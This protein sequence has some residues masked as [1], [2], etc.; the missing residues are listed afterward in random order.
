MTEEGEEES[1]FVLIEAVIPAASAGGTGTLAVDG[2]N[3]AGGTEANNAQILLSGHTSNPRLEDMVELFRQGI[4]TDDDNDL[5]QE[6]VPRHGETTTDSGNWRRERIICPRK[7]RNLQN[8][9]ASFIHYSHDSIL[10]MSLLQLFLIMFREDYLEE[11]LIPETN[12]VLNVPMDLQEFIK[13]VGCWLYMAC[14]VGI[15]SR[16]DWWSTMTPS[17][18][19]GAPFRLNLIISRNQ[20]DSILSALRFTNGEVPYEDGFFQ[21]RQLEEAWNHNMAQH[22]LP[23]WI[24]VIDEYMM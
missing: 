24:N 1:L 21:M 18:D 13:W 14:W 4:T 6:N 20:F 17:M 23:S 2:N 5:A 7:A 12:K 22:F 11:V 8:T 9:F 3:R 10:C 19:K 15:E 16:Q